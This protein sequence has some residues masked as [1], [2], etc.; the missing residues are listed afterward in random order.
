MQMRFCLSQHV[1]MSMDV[2]ST[3]QTS[4]SIPLLWTIGELYRCSQNFL[5]ACSRNVMHCHLS[6]TVSLQR[7]TY[8]QVMLC[9]L[10]QCGHVQPLYIEYY[11]ISSRFIKQDAQKKISSKMPK[12]ELGCYYTYVLQHILLYTTECKMQLQWILS[13]AVS[14]VAKCYECR[15]LPAQTWSKVRVLCFLCTIISSIW[16]YVY[17]PCILQ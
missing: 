3:M 16:G 4:H 5:I 9:M 11:Y 10:N 6:T 2:K 7:H 12:A 15:L 1:Y 14:T 13:S 17:M 8:R